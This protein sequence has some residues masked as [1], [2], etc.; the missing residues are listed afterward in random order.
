MKISTAFMYCFFGFCSFFLNAQSSDKQLKPNNYKEQIVHSYYLFQKY[1]NERLLDSVLRFIKLNEFVIKEDSIN[2]K[3]YY[4]KGVSNLYLKRYEKADAYFLKSFDLAKKTND[5]LLKGTIYNSRGVCVSMGKKN[6][7]KA[8][9]FYKKAINNYVKINELPQ[10]I[11]SYYNLTLNERKRKNW[12]KSSEYAITCLKLIDEDKERVAGISRLYYFIADNSFELNKN[13]EAIQNLQ[14]AEKYAAPDDSY[15][16]GFINETYAKIYE[17]KKEYTLALERYKKVNKN[18]RQTN[19]KNEGKLSKSFIEELD[20]ESKLKSEKEAII[21]TQNKQ[22]LVSV[23]IIVT[24]LLLTLVLYWLI[25]KNKKKNNRIKQLN[26]DLQSLILNLKNKNQDL[27]DKKQEIENLLKLNEQATFSRVLKINT[28]NDAIRKITDDIEIYTEN[29][30]SASSYLITVNKKLLA[31][32]S[33]E[34]LWQDFKIQFEKIRPD[35]FNKLKE[36]TPSLSINDLKH[37]T[38]IISNLKSKEVAQ[39]INVSPR[40][41]ETTRYRIKKKMGLDKEDN[42]YDL[43]SVL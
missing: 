42:I 40:S 1:E 35:F 3:I 24:F 31:L 39:L 6:Y 41:V 36:H 7:I 37:C 43:L 25:K 18:L 12:G 16:N 11:D 23:L 32:I 14:K 9:E 21:N 22:L 8:E 2:S 27:V 30:S 19:E 34:E 4:L 13:E 26:S 28:Y 38:Y 5:I 15:V 10:Q 20:L 33:E 29:N 17:S